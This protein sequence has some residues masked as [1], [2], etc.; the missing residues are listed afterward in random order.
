[1]KMNKGYVIGI[2]GTRY[3]NIVSNEKPYVQSEYVIIKDE[4]HGDLICEVKETS[5]IPFAEDTILPKG[6]TVNMLNALKF[7]TLRPL[8]FAK[9]KILKEISSPVM[10]CSCVI[11]ASYEEISKIIG[12]ASHDDCMTIGIIKGTEHS[13]NELPQEIQN[14]APL[15]EKGLAVHQEGIPLMLNYHAFREYP[16]IGAFGSSGSG[17]SFGLRVIIEELMKLNIPILAFDP[18]MEIKFEDSMN[19]LPDELKKNFKDKY[20]EFVIG[21]NVGIKF[22]DL[23]V[24][25]L[26]TLFRYVDDLTEPQKNALE[27]LYEK[28][29]NFEHLKNKIM[30]LKSALDKEEQRHLSK[31]KNIQLTPFETDLLTTYKNKVSGSASL[32]ALLWKCIS[33]ENTNIF[34]SDISEVKRSMKKGKLAVIRGD[35]NRLKMIA[36]YLIG[37]LYKARRYYK[38]ENGEFF[39]PFF[40]FLDEAHNFA[41]AEGKDLPIRSILRKIGQ[42]ARK[43]GVF[44]G[45]STQRPRSLDKTLLAQLNTKFI[46]RLTDQQDMEVAKVEGNLTDEEVSMLPDLPSGSCY[47]SSAILNKTYPVRFRTTFSK[48]PNVTDPFD[49]LKVMLSN[50]SNELE[51]VLLDFMPINTM[52]LGSQ[53]SDI[54]QRY[55]KSVSINDVLDALK[56]LESQ[57]VINV[58]SSHLG[59]IYSR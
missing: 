52:R 44:L 19:G 56:N 2:T 10:P 43:Y 51:T 37:K 7:N 55:N 29:D 46:F 39:P 54:S 5:I 4:L 20:D 57:G 16:H 21:E 31:N 49:E 25:E 12:N 47:V 40:A 9:V 3:I 14:V 26:I 28:G 45:L 27:V 13:Q 24:S 11:G 50:E 33:L 48:A 42:E 41:P 18:H 6:C 8:F 23:N 53:L 58:K 17:K 22:T 15:W 59:K 1:M 34:V 35:I 36:S 32:Q 38:D 30:S